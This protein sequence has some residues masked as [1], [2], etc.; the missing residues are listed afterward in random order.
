MGLHRVLAHKK[1]LGDFAVAQ[2]LGYEFKDLKLAVSDLQ[3]L[4]FSLVRDERSPGS[5]GTSFPTIV[6][7]SCHPV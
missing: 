3:V 2:A 4:S 1:L 7:V 5:D 6:A